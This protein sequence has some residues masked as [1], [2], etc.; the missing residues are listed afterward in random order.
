MREIKFRAWDEE[1]KYFI[2]LGIGHTP[3]FFNHEGKLKSDY[4]C[5]KIMQYTGLKDKNGKE[6]YEGDIVKWNQYFLGSKKAEEI[7]LKT[8]T[9]YWHNGA[10][11]L[12]EDKGWNASIYN[13][14]EVI[15]NI[16]ENPELLNP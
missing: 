14:I 9:V 8:S 7:E 10:W 1:R 2:E 4:G 6:I 12:S 15:G 3:L 11:V 16:Y 13:N 5:I